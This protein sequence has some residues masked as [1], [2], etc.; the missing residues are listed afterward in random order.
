[1]DNPQ[2]LL[3]ASGS[4]VSLA[5]DAARALAER[6]VPAR[7]ISV[8]S[9][10]LFELQDEAYK[11]TI[12]PP[13]LPKVVIEAGVSQGWHKYTGP[14]ARFITIDNRFGASAPYKDIFKHLG[15][16]VE[17]VVEEALALLAS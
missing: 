3:V 2:I 17:H 15:F 5:L 11:R 1:M 8:P 14:L 4:E 6:N 13:N 16:T 12:F 10:E 9:W 7:V